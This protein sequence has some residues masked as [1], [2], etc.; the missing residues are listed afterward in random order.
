V[1]N[2]LANQTFYCTPA[3]L[4]LQVLPSGNV[5]KVCPFTN[6]SQYLEYIGFAHVDFWFNVGMLGVLTFGYRLLSMGIFMLLA[7][8]RN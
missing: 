4:V 5:T 1:A 6:G 3:Q 2:E 8:E 7:A